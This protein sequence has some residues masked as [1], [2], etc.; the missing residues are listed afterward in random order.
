MNTKDALIRYIEKI[1]GQTPVIK[2]VPKKKM[3]KVPLYLVELYDLFYLKLFERELVLAVAR[4]QEDG[5]TP[6]EYAAHAEQ[7]RD[8]LGE[9]IALVLPHVIAYNRDRLIKQ[10]VAFIV[11]GRQLFLPQLLVDLR[12]NFP[13]R[14]RSSRE[15]LSYPAQLVVL[16]HLLKASIEPYSLRELANRF[17]YSAMTLSNVGDELSALALCEDRTTGRKRNLHFEA[18]GRQ[19]WKKFLPYLRT[20]VQARHWVRGIPFRISGIKA[21]ITALSAYTAIEDDSLPTYAMRNTAYRKRLETGELIGC[22]GPDE[23][24]AQIES[25]FYVPAILADDNRVD[26]LS[27]FLT[28]HESSD[29]RVTKALRELL[30]RVQW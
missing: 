30:G 24:E 27:L 29:E 23:A 14:K 5:F 26:K 18:R 6:R 22:H 4:D 28:L 9:I 1:I 17:G 16:Y 11:P 2:P 10:G 3:A 20:P 8:A 15:S 12:N 13:R 7:L 21:G 19:L 25:W